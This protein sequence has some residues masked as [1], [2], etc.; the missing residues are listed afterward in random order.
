MVQRLDQ[1]LCIWHKF[2][3]TIWG[4]RRPAPRRRAAGGFGA[5]AAAFLGASLRPALKSFWICYSFLRNSGTV[6]WSS[7]EK[8]GLMAKAWAERVPVGVARRA[9]QA[10]VPVVAIVGV[11]GPDCEAVY[12]AG[13]TAIFPTNREALPFSELAARAAE[14]YRRTLR[15]LLRYTRAIT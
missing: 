7:P 9:K 8:G 10:G 15:D 3:R 14:D 5:G 6:I 1:G 11:V 4:I 2:W 13:I 12:D